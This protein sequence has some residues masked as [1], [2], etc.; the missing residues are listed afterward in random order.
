MTHIMVPDG[1]F[2]PWLWIGGWVLAVICLGLALR[3]IRSSDTVRMLPL[4]ATMAAVM[5]IAMSLPT[6][7]LNYELHLTVLSGILLGPAYGLLATFVFMVLRMLVGDGAITM[8]GLNTIIVG[9]ETVGGYYLFRALSRIW[10]SPRQVGINAGIAT[11]IALAIATLVFLAVVAI[12]QA[13]LTAVADPDLLAR[14]GLEDPGLLAYA[15][16]VLG[17]GAIGWIIEA[18]VVGAITAF[19]GAVRPS[20]IAAAPDPHIFRKL[21]N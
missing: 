11:V 9:I 18:V 1:V 19:I 15:S 2:P 7:F 4:A 21:R 17:L 13:D 10:R 6:D 3:A 8:L 12:S 5:T 14:T 20:L 16:V